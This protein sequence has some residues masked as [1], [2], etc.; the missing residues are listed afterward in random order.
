MTIF[1]KY[2]LRRLTEHVV[3]LVIRKCYEGILESHLSGL[4]GTVGHPNVK[5][6]RII[7]FSFENMLHWQFEVRL[8]LFTVCICV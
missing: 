8:L 3:Q 5:K 2:K 4:T 7:G 6:N 1:G